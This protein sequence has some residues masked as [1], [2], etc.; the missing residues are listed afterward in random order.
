MELTRSSGRSTSLAG[1]QSGLRY[2]LVCL[3][4]RWK[5]PLNAIFKV[6]DQRKCG[7]VTR[8]YRILGELRP[9]VGTRP[10][11]LPLALY[12]SCWP[13]ACL[14][15]SACARLIRLAFSLG[16]DLASR[17]SVLFSPDCPLLL[18]RCC[19]LARFSVG[20]VKLSAD[21]IQIVFREQIKSI[22]MTAHWKGICR[23]EM[24]SVLISPKQRYAVI[25]K[26]RTMML[27]Y[28]YILQR[29]YAEINMH[30]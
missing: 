20:R 28:M 19:T 12:R 14:P 2:K 29:R 8:N 13:P 30:N 17:P 18:R 11:A 7:W 27:L 16:S 26:G 6:S 22:L 9:T 3:P 4:R 23:F 5:G 10:F 1:A 24:D 15:A 25:R 21:T